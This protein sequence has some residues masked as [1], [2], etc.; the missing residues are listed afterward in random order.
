MTPMLP[1]SYE[2]PFAI[3]LVLGGALSCFAGYRLFKI[4]LAIFG[5]FLGALLVSSTMGLSNT[6]GMITGAIVGGI[7]GV[8]ILA[9]AYFIGNALVGAG[10]G[11]A[12]AHI[13]WGVMRS[14][15]P[16]VALVIV[17]TIAG[18]LAALVLRRYVI[19]VGTAFG[20]A[21]TV[22]LGALAV[23]GDR[24]ALKAAAGGDV[25]ILYPIPPAPGRGWMTVAWTVLGLAGTAVQLGM[26]GKKRR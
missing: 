14:G 6:T 1:P 24:T 21:W 23:A 10:I 5:F 3:L 16:P 8:L 25:W 19:T 9:F 20:G 7:V 26:G 12:V 15:D 2:L 18:A 13:G 4:V 11:A 17:A 22:I